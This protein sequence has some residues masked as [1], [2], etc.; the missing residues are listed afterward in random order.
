MYQPVVVTGASR[1]IGR[2]LALAFA[3]GKH[4]LVLCARSVDLEAVADEGRALGVEVETV[5]CNLAT[6]E[7]REDLVRAVDGPVAG[8]VNNA[9]FGTAGEFAVQDPARERELIRLNIEAVVDLTHAFLPRMSRGSFL[10]NVSSTAGFQP[11]PLFATYAATK[12]FVLSFSQALAEELAPAGIHVIALCPGVT[13]TGFQSV[14]EIETSSA[15]TATAEEVAAFAL[16]ALDKRRRVAIHG[17]RN[18][19]MIHSQRFAPRGLVVKIAR[20]VMEPWFRLR[21][22]P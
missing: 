5:R 13:A 7:G 20:R 11:V 10:M 15:P 9:G 8:L 14:A 16:R 6:V 3:R 1:G 12:A 19:L 21:R 22:P 2:A 4:D 18:A 17:R